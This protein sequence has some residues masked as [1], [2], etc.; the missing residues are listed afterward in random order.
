MFVGHITFTGTG[1]FRSLGDRTR[2]SQVDLT[3]RGGRAA[4]YVVEGRSSRPKG[5]FPTALHAP[6]SV[7][8][9]LLVTCTGNRSP[10]TGLQDANTVVVACETG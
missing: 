10:T 8:M 6:S 2:G 5:E 3:M 7:P 9:I 1:V 4:G